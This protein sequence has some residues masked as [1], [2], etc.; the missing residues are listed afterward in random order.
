MDLRV[1]EYFLAVAEEQNVTRASERLHISQPTLSRQIMQLED[2]FGV[3]LLVRGNKS[4]SLT[5]EGKILK[6][7]A[8]EI[9]SLCDKVRAEVQNESRR[10]SGELYIGIL[11]T[12][13]FQMIAQKMQEFGELYPEV[14]FHLITASSDHIAEQVEKGLID[15][16]VVS[17]PIQEDR[18]GYKQLK[19]ERMRWGLIVPKDHPLAE[20]K[21]VTED[22][23]LNERLIVSKR[24][25]DSGNYAKWFRKLDQF[26]IVAT[27]N[28]LGNAVTMV[29]EGMG[30]VLGI[31][32]ANYKSTGLKFI[33]FRPEIYDNPT[34]LIWKRNHTFS[35][36]ASYFLEYVERHNSYTQK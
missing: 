22:D 27:Y 13:A 31:D 18:F 20:K 12:S 6:E 21:Y 26:N 11:E 1:L 3:E 9:L 15:M 7:R 23:I 2:E 32:H 30:V 5:P 28:L 34:Y 29:R 24:Q 19:V 4:V 8:K 36:A 25:I 16:G 10:I 14:C 35:K 33:S 17:G